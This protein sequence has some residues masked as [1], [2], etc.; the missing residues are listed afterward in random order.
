M[1]ELAHACTALV[2]VDAE[3]AFAFLADA[4]ALGG[5]ALGSWGAS[6]DRAGRFHGRSLFS[7]EETWGRIDADPA[8]LLIDYLVGSR[9]D[10][11]RPRISAR[12]VPGPVTGRPDEVCLITLTAWR[13]AGMDD[14]RW[15]QLVAAHE[16]EILLI[17]GQLERS[18]R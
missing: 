8:R 6:V 18:R 15:Q 11:L 12:V 7:G 3:T 13:A 1:K 5:W 2:E 14:V 16:A 17:K 4:K 9:P 10:D